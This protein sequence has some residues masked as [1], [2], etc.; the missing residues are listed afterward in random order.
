MLR[1]VVCVLRAV[2]G[3]REYWRMIQIDHAWVV[4]RYHQYGPCWALMCCVVCVRVLCVCCCAWLRVLWLCV[5]CVWGL[6]VLEGWQDNHQHHQSGP[7]LEYSWCP[8]CCVVVLWAQL[9]WTLKRTA[10]LFTQG[11]PFHPLHLPHLFPH[12]HSL[13][14]WLTPPHFNLH[15]SINITPFMLGH[16]NIILTLLSRKPQS[17]PLYNTCI[18]FNSTQDSRLSI[19]LLWTWYFPNHHAFIC[20]PPPILFILQI[21][22]Y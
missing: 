16:I 17:S 5:G 8:V 15:R 9:L 14:Y 4:A 6:P 10:L 22:K 18:P 7:L 2:H 12:L 13:I 19:Y 1:V 20:T 11:Q 3:C 21:L